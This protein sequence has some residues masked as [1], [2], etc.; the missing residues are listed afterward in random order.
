MAE[1]TGHR[2]RIDFAGTFDGNN[3]TITGL[4]INQSATDNVGLFASI[5]EGG[6][7]QKMD[8]DWTEAMNA[9]NAALTNAGTDWRYA[10]GSG[11]PLTLQRQN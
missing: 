10:T 5:A 1:V 8:G 11:A 4:T 2:Y 7:A 3:K 9:M 6:N